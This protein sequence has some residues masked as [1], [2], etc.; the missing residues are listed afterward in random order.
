MTMAVMV[1]GIFVKSIGT[2]LIV[3][4]A[5]FGGMETFGIPSCFLGDLLG[6]GSVG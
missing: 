6:G 5:S 2:Y 4:T 1:A 3:P